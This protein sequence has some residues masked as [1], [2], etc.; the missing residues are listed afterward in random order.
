MLIGKRGSILYTLGKIKHEI[1]YVTILG[2][3]V[4]YFSHIFYD[5]IPKMPIVI[6]SFLGT[7]ISVLLSFKLNQSYDRWWEARKIWGSIVNESRSFV[8][9]LQSFVADG[10]DAEIKQIA[11][12]QIAWCFSLGQS[13]RGLDPRENLKKYITDEDL[14]NTERHKNV[15]L[16]LLQL[17]ALQIK[18]LKSRNQIDIYSQVRLN[19]TLANLTDAM[20]MTER[21]KNTIFP[22]TYRLFL[23]VIIYIFV[24]TLSISLDGISALYNI[25]LLVTISTAFFLLERT[26][27]DLQD[28]FKNRPTDTEMTTIATN[29]EIN[30]KQLLNE[31]DIPELFKQNK[32]YS[33]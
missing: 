11:F 23:H 21:I 5:T 30:I 28:P 17:N 22:V 18:N 20:G 33:L 2:F 27:S 6:P 4:S 29:I 13:L 12:R 19:T 10:N 25:P 9:Q 24:V 16:S 8:L 26:A 14:M 15:P 32:F 31:K 1:L 7:A 3:V